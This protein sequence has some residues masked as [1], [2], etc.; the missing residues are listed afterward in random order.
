MYL[1]YFLGGLAICLGLLSLRG[2]FLFAAYVSS[3][4]EAP[5]HSFTPYASVIV[6]C[7]GLDQGFSENIRA[8]FHQDY[9]HYEVIFVTGDLNDPCI[10]AIK[11]VESA[12]NNSGRIT[13]RM[14]LAGK[15]TDSGQKVH[16]LRVAT[17]QLSVQTKV[18]AFV[19]SDARPNSQWLSAL[20]APLANDQIGATTGYRWFIPVK[21]GFASH[22]R[23]VW[24]ASIA[25]ALGALNEKNFCWGGSTAIRRSVFQELL[26]RERWQGTVSD[27][28]T[29]TRVLQENHRPIHFIPS[30]LVPSF[31]DCGFRELLEFTNR[32]LKIT[33]VYAP[34]LWKP[35]LAGS[36]L[37]VLVFFGGL[38]LIS[39]HTFHGKFSWVASVMLLLI[40]FLGAAKSYIRLRAVE[41]PL[42]E[43]RSELRKS[44]AA[45]LLLWPFASMLYL[46]NSLTA[47]FS[48]TIEWRGTKYKLKSPGETVIIDRN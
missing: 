26:I 37:F 20:V 9:S 2:G 22:L 48:R 5:D 7:R 36:L 3:H 14:V 19:D 13:T 32:Q 41:T 35:L 43:Y 17:D 24:N 39:F 47:A 33:R 45:H 28:F 4:N 16:N 38:L 31:E 12:E 10:S 8:L 15:A 27:D 30:C 23:S 46:I 6:P 25:S 40:F 21:G 44:L 29:L 11:E 1:F 42:A 34:H 18:L